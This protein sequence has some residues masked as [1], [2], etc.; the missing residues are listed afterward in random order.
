MT[1]SVLLVSKHIRNPIYTGLF[2]GS[3]GLLMISPSLILLSGLLVGYAAVELF[4]RKVEEPYLR[5]QF[6]PEYEWFNA[7]PRYF[8]RLF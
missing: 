2:V 3:I 8:P 6:G 7:T 1:T 5:E 4:V